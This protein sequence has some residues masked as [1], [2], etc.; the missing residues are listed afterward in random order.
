MDSFFIV[1]IKTNSKLTIKGITSTK[2]NPMMSK[3]KSISMHQI[4]SVIIKLI[5]LIIFMDTKFA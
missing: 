3:N 4:N 2:Q 1:R 5:C